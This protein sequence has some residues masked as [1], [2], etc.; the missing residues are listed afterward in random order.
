MT[1]GILLSMVAVLGISF[2]GKSMISSTLDYIG[3]EV[4]QALSI[5]PLL[6]NFI[7]LS[8]LLTVLGLLLILNY[9]HDRDM[10]LEEAADKLRNDVGSYY[11]SAI[12][13]LVE[14]VMQDF[15]DAIDSAERHLESYIEAA[16]ESSVNKPGD[17]KRSKMTPEYLNLERLK[18]DHKQIQDERAAL[19]KIKRSL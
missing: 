9:I 11:Q 4:A 16:T 13:R 19:Q 1:L 18:R 10:R 14:K 15:N 17:S 12:K 5:S 2:N 3:K 6:A 8:I 7:N